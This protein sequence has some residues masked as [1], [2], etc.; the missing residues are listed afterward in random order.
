MKSIKEI[1]AIRDKKRAEIIDMKP[2]TEGIKTRVVV[3]YA[4]CG[5]AAGATPVLE[6]LKKEVANKKL[7]NVEVTY[8]GCL[9]MCKLEPIVEVTVPG[10]PKI[11]YI[12]VDADKAKDIVEKHLIGGT[13]CEEYM[14][15]SEE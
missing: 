5:M 15:S 10:K 11:T 8:A 13:P 9:G 7:K 14:I 3:G 12:F 1:N 6:T 4:T 2:E